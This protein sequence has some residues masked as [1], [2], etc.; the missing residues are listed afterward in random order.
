MPLDDP[1]VG[2]KSPPIH[3]RW[4][5]GTSGNPSGRKRGSKNWKTMFAEAMAAKITVNDEGRRRRVSKESS[6]FMQL[7]NQAAQG[8]PKARQDVRR[9]REYID[10]T[11]PAKE[12][13]A[14]DKPGFRIPVV[15]LPYNSR[16]PLHP[17]LK[18]LYLKAFQEFC[19]THPEAQ[20]CG[21]P[22]GEDKPS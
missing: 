19:D 14:E 1:P 4:P 10:R 9:L 21:A 18:A 5:P 20:H 7:A 13:A 11:S 22:F 8:D 12:P 16:D 17:D 3:P 2:Y 6:M 15:I